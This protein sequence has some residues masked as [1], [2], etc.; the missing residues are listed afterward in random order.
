LSGAVSDT[1]ILSG[2][3][4][5]VLSGGIANGITVSTGGT[6][7]IMSGAIV[8]G[9]GKISAIGHNATLLVE[10][11]IV[12]VSSGGVV[13]DSGAQMQLQALSGANVLRSPFEDD[14][15]RHRAR[16]GPAEEVS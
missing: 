11:Q 13:L 15:G 5:D 3:A 10:A 1:T 12:T 2:G 16:G 7:Q 9:S 4:L 8:S 14:R 6:A